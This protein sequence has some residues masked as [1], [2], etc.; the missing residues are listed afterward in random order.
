MVGQDAVPK[1]EKVEREE[2]ESLV[3]PEEQMTVA[4]CVRELRD[5]LEDFL[6]DDRLGPEF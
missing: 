4:A 3:G 5:L 6:A 1:R 2:V